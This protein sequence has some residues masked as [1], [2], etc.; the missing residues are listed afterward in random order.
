MRSRQ[1]GGGVEHVWRQDGAELTLVNTVYENYWCCNYFLTFACRTCFFTLDWVYKVIH[2]RRHALVVTFL[3]GSYP[4]CSSGDIMCVGRELWCVKHNKTTQWPTST[5][6]TFGISFG[7]SHWTHIC[8]VL[9]ITEGV[10]STLFHCWREFLAASLHADVILHLRWLLLSVSECETYK[11][12]YFT[13]VFVRKLF[14]EHCPLTTAINMVKY[15]E[16]VMYFSLYYDYDY[17]CYYYIVIYVGCRQDPNA[18]PRRQSSDA[19]GLF[20]I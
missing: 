5:V 15:T 4:V 12:L 2:H 7:F 11:H 20:N 18:V 17:Y 13:S 6:H 16:F 3:K 14:I 1:A 9:L 8:G 19:E 10:Y